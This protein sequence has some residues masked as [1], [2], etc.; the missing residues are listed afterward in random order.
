MSKK[1]LM[2]Q[3]RKETALENIMAFYIDNRAIEL[4]EHEE[5]KKNQYE[6][7]FTMLIEDDSIVDTVS[8]LCDLFQISK[9]TAYKVISEAEAIFGSVKKFNKEAWKFIQIERKRRLITLA[10][11]A[12]ELELVAKLEKQI[13]DIIGFDKDEAA[14]DPDKIKAQT[15]E[16]KIPKHLETALA[17]LVG[18]GVVDM[19][20]IIDVPHEDVTN[21]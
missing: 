8:K 1:R 20:S 5:N 12:G 11:N 18:K 2:T 7:A 19:N 14:F 10:T 3:T 16:I 17:K 6:A 15:Y 21:G 13:D 4:T 9:A